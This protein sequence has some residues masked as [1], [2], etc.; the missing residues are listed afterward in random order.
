[1]QM[2]GLNASS[3]NLTYTVAQLQQAA[4]LEVS[5]LTKEQFLPLMVTVRPAGSSPG[6]QPSAYIQD[7]CIL[8]PWN[9]VSFPHP[10]PATSA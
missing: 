4:G 6:S 3:S 1:M 9:S 10:L 5:P 2:E 7:T 8:Y